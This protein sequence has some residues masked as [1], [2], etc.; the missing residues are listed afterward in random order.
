MNPDLG[1]SLTSALNAVIS[2][3]RQHTEDTSLWSR[4]KDFFGK[5]ELSKQLSSSLTSLKTQGY[6]PQDFIEHQINWNDVKWPIDACIDFGFTFDNMLTMGF[7][8]QHFK[9]FEWRHYKQLN[10]NAQHMMQTGMAIH[11]LNQLDL[12]P[13]QLHQLKWT[14]GNFVTIGGNDENIPFSNADKQLYFQKNTVE[15]TQQ[16]IG[17]FVF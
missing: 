5:K 12:T 16:K 4:T 1:T 8:P 6:I 13:Q 15:T 9:Q 7:Q 14:W 11:D 17:R 10:V 2:A 3:R